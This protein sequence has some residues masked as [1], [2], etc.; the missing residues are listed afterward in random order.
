M[1][2]AFVTLKIKATFAG[3]NPANERS[4]RLLTKLG[5]TC[6]HDELYPPTGLNHPSYLVET[7]DFKQASTLD[8]RDKG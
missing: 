1:T 5:F 3:H 6:T 2:Y 8:P 4:R 7:A